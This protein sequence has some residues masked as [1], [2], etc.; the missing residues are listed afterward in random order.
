MVCPLT[1]K[2]IPSQMGHHPDQKN[3][4]YAAWVPITMV[5]SPLNGTSY[6]I[7]QGLTM[8]G[9]ENYTMPG[10]RKPVSFFSASLP[11]R[12]TRLDGSCFTENVPRPID[13]IE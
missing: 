13:V 2:L 5:V 12:L 6:E 4:V 8:L 7:C 1:N 3:R 11:V 10:W 9:M